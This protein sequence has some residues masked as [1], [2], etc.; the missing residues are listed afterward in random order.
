MLC[1]CGCHAV[2]PEVQTQESGM[3]MS[4]KIKGVVGK[5]RAGLQPSEFGGND[6]NDGGGSGAEAVQDCGTSSPT[7][8]TMDTWSGS[9]SGARSSCPLCFLAS[10]YI[11]EVQLWSR[12]GTS[13]VWVIRASL[14]M[15][16]GEHRCWKPIHDRKTK[17]KLKWQ[18]VSQH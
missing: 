16:G 6:G 14:S 5:C 9:H 10:D 8:Q 13:G 15:L 17:V 1:V 18:K 11:L 4:T 7:E 3:S 12:D 2:V